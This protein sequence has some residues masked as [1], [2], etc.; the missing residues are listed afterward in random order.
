[1]HREEVLTGKA[2]AV[3][4]FAL[5]LDNAGFWIK[6]DAGTVAAVPHTGATDL[7]SRRHSC[8]PVTENRSLGFSPG[9]F[10]NPIPSAA[11]CRSPGIPD[12]EDRNRSLGFSPGK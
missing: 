12:A 4:S 3:Q 7:C 11:D 8:R 6:H 5:M 2:G 9:K 10:S 1:M